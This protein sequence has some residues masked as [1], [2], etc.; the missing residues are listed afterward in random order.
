MENFTFTFKLEEINLIL[1]A[2]G[3]VAYK[4]SVKVI[5]GIH[6]QAEAQQKAKQEEVP[7]KGSKSVKGELV[8]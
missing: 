2:L 6:E 3:N 7:Q 4:K 1:E 8:D 5:A